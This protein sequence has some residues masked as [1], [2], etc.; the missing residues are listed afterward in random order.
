MKYVFPT[1]LLIISPLIAIGFVAH[2]VW[3]ALTIGW[4]WC[5]DLLDRL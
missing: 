1:I 2:I 4:T 3:V 5:E